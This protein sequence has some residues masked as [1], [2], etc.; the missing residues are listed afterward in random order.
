MRPLA[1]DTIDVVIDHSRF[2]WTLILYLSVCM[3]DFQDEKY[4]HV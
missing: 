4:I 3:Y 2:I 1:N